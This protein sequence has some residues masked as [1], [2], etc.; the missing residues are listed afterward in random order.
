MMYSLLRQLAFFEDKIAEYEGLAR[1]LD[2]VYAGTLGP[3]G[4]L[5]V[6]WV[7]L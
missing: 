7:C 5:F 4:S 1:K 6:S 2:A 3:L